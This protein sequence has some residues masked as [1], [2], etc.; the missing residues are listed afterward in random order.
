MFDH[1]KIWM[2][3]QMVPWKEANVHVLSHGLSRGSAIFEVFGIHPGPEGPLA[4]RMD[5]HLERLFRSAEL[6]GMEM[7]YTPEQIAAAV[8]ESVKEN[9]ISRG[10][11]KIMAFYGEQAV[12]ALVLDSKLDLA[13][14]GI[15]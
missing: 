14:C 9:Q 3:G 10:L 8:A 13:I 5:K 4:F 7:A 1:L 15:P 2:N 11:I 12:I 6:L